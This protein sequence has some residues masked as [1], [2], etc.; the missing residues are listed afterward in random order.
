[1]TVII[2]NAPHGG[3]AVGMLMEDQRDTAGSAR[4]ENSLIKGV[5]SVH[6]PANREVENLYN[7]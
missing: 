1:M 7:H 4:D 6:H 3:R 5:I 2:P